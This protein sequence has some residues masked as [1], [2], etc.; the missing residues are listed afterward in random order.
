MSI[1]LCELQESS[2][3]RLHLGLKKTPQKAVKISKNT[4]MKRIISRELMKQD[5]GC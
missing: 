3:K 4:S 1:K 2:R 5:E